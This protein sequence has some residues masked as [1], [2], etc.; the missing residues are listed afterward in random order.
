METC[1]VL[2]EF[3]ADVIAVSRLGNKVLYQYDFCNLTKNNK[4]LLISS[5]LQCS[6][7]ILY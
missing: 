1:I 6:N 5:K 2:L 3:G 7:G 4:M